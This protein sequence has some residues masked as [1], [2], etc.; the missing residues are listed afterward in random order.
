MAEQFGLEQ[1][2][3][4]RVAIHRHE[5]PAPARA[6]Q[7]HGAGA[8]FLARAGLAGDQNGG[9]PA[10]HQ[11]NDLGDLAHF[12]AGA[13]EEGLPF[14]ALDGFGQAAQAALLALA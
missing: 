2:L 5:R 13:D 11:A 6:C 9:A 14:L 1:A 12:A 7:V 10:A 4:Q 3:R 8:D